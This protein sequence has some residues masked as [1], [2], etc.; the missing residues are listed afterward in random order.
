M[1][2]VLVASTYTVGPTLIYHDVLLQ[3]MLAEALDISRETYLAIVMDQSY[4]GPVIIASPE[5]GVDIEEVAEK[6]PEKVFKLPVDIMEGV[7]DELA[8]KV[9][10]CL[11][12]EGKQQVEAAKQVK[13]LYNMFCAVDTTQVEINP[14][15][16]TPDGRGMCITYCSLLGLCVCV[17]LHAMCIICLIV[18]C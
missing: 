13:S 6:S 18:Y 15:G 2:T 3:V 1:T 7:T 4:D 12:F 17:D 8:V 11:E 16:E 14:F 5:G 10:K 9:A